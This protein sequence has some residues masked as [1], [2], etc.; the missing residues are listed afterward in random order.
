MSDGRGSS[1][2]T[3]YTTWLLSPGLLVLSGSDGWSLSVQIQLMSPLMVLHE[4]TYKV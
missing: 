1:L 3:R 2:I 4:L